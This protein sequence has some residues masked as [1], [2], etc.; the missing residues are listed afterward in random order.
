MARSSPL[1]W[2][3]VQRQLDARRWNPARLAR[4]IAK[5]A[6][7][8]SE[9]AIG[10]WQNQGSAPSPESVHA[11][12]KAFH[13]DVRK[14]LAAANLATARE[15]NAPWLDPSRIDLTAMPDEA[16][17]EQMKELAN[18][19]ATRLA[20]RAARPLQP[21]TATVNGTNHATTTTATAAGPS[22]HIIPAAETELV[23]PSS[24][25]DEGMSVDAGHCA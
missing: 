15:L 17:A 18:E 24:D 25:E 9:S 23:P 12:A 11:V 4:E 2:P 22:R 21:A 1:W 14:A 3:W 7:G 8:P 16:L 6:D 20:R 10:R 13:V 19:A 5:F